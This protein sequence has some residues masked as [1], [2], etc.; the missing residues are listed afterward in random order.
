[1]PAIIKKFYILYLLINLW[2]SKSFFYSTCYFYIILKI[3]FF[4]YINFLH[5]NFYSINGVVNI[6]ND[7]LSILEKQLIIDDVYLK[8]ER[9]LSLPLFIINIINNNKNKI[10]EYLG[11][12]FY[13]ENPGIYETFSLPDP[14]KK[15]DIYANVW[16]L[17]SD[18][19]K[20]LKVF[21]LMHDVK[22]NDGPLVYLDL[23]NTKKNWEILKDRG[24]KNSIISIESENKFVGPKGSYLI[25][26][27][28]RNLHRAS[29]PSNKR[30]MFSISLYPSF[31]KKV[32]LPRYKWDF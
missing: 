2:I 15:I 22:E 14:F 8:H 7:N 11:K 24:N 6:E 29:V 20:V 25:I 4:N 1:M 12:N 31:V 23:D 21:V 16:H 13:Y 26:D 28:S 3:K 30:Q 32:D 9:L 5:K 27:T 17:D 18:T 10:E 19:Y